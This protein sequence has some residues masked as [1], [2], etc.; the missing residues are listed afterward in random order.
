MKL[1]DAVKLIAKRLEEQ[2]LDVVMCISLGRRQSFLHKM[3]SQL[4][5]RVVVFVA[6][7]SRDL[8]VHMAYP[9]SHVLIATFRD[10]V[11]QEHNCK[12]YLEINRSIVL[13]DEL[14]STKKNMDQIE[15]FLKSMSKVEKIF[16]GSD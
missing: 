2:S 3:I 8:S 7:N 13:V 12:K 5:S 11:E 1:Q 14:R 6:K 9:Y 10:F 15:S 16:L 4:E